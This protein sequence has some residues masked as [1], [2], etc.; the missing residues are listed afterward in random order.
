VFEDSGTI[1]GRSESASRL[2]GDKSG[3]ESKLCTDRL[4]T[5][6]GDDGMCI[7]RVLFQRSL[8]ELCKFGSRCSRSRYVVSLRIRDQ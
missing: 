2:V 1:V 7:D 8:L 5:E 6:L 3:V 4:V